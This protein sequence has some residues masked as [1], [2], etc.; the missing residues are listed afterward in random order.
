MLRA[1]FLFLSRNARLRRF[2]ETSSVAKALS[3]RFIAGST[4]DEALAVCVKIR[5]D[6]IAAT[7][8][9]L[10]ENVKS[11]N[12]AAAC[13]DVYL[14]V[15][16]GLHAAGL[17]P[18]VSLKLT[19]FGL[20]FSP[21][22]CE[23]NVAAVVEKASEIGGFIRIDMESSAYTDRTLGIV[24]RLHARYGSC[25]TVIQAY[26][27]RSEA[28]VKVLIEEG[29]RVR[30]CK[31]AYLEP[32][33]IAFPKKSD[34]DKNYRVLA[35]QLLTN[36]HYPAIA[37]HDER[38]IEIVERFAKNRGIVRDRFEFQMLYG[39]R[40]DLQKHLVGQGYRMRLYVPFGEAWYPYFMR[41]LAERPANVLFLLRNLVR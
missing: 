36:G 32:P 37:T 3:A 1:T 25:G 26:L 19:Q 5:S 24:R 28:D 38:M 8:D 30:L 4:L 18:N 40:R 15:L 9:Y 23:Q 31:G 39:I 17:E 14:R 16:A 33:D 27:R 35:E 21:E 41:R 6:G 2:S 34:V 22:A 11:L 20:D 7:L 29:V 12:E 10:G 13:R